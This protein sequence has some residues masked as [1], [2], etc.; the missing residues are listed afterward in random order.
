MHV[1]RTVLFYETIVSFFILLA[2][3]YVE[4]VKLNN[5]RLLQ[6]NYH[7]YRTFNIR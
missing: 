3:S 6:N 5:G 1:I 7:N 2:F 4:S